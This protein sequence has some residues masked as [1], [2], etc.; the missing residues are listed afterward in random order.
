MPHPKL[1][2][3]ICDSYFGRSDAEE[4]ANQFG[5][6]LFDELY[7]GG[8]G[9][10][11][12][13]MLGN[14]GERPVDAENLLVFTGT[15]HG[16]SKKAITYATRIKAENPRAKIYFRSTDFFPPESPIFDGILKKREE[17]KFHDII[18]EF[19]EQVRQ[20]A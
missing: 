9:G 19:V 17:E 20:T 10:S 5:L 14:P 18:R 16:D 2:V 11:E 8:A 15:F 7:Y 3:F 4:L 1:F 6:Q 13:V 12:H